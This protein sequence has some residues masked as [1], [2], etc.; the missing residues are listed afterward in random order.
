MVN[1]LIASLASLMLI[2][3]TVNYRQQFNDVLNSRNNYS[4]NSVNEAYLN[5]TSLRLYSYSDHRID[6]VL[7]NT[8]INSSCTNLML[9]REVTYIS[10]DV[11]NNSQIKILNYSG[12]EQQYNALGITYHFDK[13]NYYAFD[14]GFINF[15]NEN[16]RLSEE[17]NICLIDKSVFAKVY[18]MYVKL[19][20]DDLAVVDAYVDKGNAKIKDSMKTLI[21]HFSNG[22][23]ANQSEEISQTSAL[24]FIIVVSIIGMTSICIFFLLK[25]KHIIE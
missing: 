24:I 13:I 12:S 5:E 9:S 21:N 25:E 20:E 1:S 6:E 18:S 14:E 16:I 23:N 11:F 8:F 7:N 2:N 10:D 4:V 15:W 22:N 3:N 17:D 19:S